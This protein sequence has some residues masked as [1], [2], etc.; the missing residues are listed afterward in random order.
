MI[1]LAS[2]LHF[3]ENITAVSGAVFGL[4]RVHRLEMLNY[5]ILL[6][7]YAQIGI[8]FLKKNKEAKGQNE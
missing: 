5:F 2:Y 7:I 1:R 3:R 8:P 4:Y 6:T